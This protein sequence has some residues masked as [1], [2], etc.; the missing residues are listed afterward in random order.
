MFAFSQKRQRR[1]KVDKKP[2]M[3]QG[4]WP[5]SS[6][7]QEDWPP[8]EVVSTGPM[9]TALGSAPA[10]KNGQ[11]FGSPQK[12][13]TTAR[14]EQLRCLVAQDKDL[15][16]FDSLNWSRFLSTNQEEMAKS[17]Q[18]AFNG[19]KLQGLEGRFLREDPELLHPD[20]QLTAH[21]FF[22]SGGL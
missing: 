17:M 11:T 7:S 22:F 19:W 13:K 10:R 2:P 16:T 8:T 6:C 1:G 12:A 20:K 18:F 15:L 14:L 9:S 5:P 3:S 21:L 4:H